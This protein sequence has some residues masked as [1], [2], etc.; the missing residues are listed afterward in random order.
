MIWRSYI[1][2]GDIPNTVISKYV[3][4][5]FK[6]VRGESFCIKSKEPS[7][8]LHKIE[9]RSLTKKQQEIIEKKICPICGKKRNLTIHHIK[10]W[11][12]F[13]DNNELGFPCRKCHSR[14]ENSVSFFETEVLKHFG[15]SYRY[16]WIVY[17]NR[18][19]ISDAAVRR[20]AKSHFMKVKNK[21]FGTSTKR[22]EKIIMKKL[23]QLK[24]IEN[25]C[26]LKERKVTV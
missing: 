20:L 15:A 6:K 12:I 9:R 13:K 16:M 26:I 4:E 25:S 14:V 24:H 22:Q 2:N 8:E 1:E 17:C 23:N 7:E 11:V 3:R 21:I 19:F 5:R 18:G 10:K